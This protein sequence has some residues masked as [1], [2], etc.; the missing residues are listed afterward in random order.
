MRFAPVALA[1]AMVK[2]ALT[3][4]RESRYGCGGVT[5]GAVAGIVLPILLLMWTEEYELGSDDGR[6]GDAGVECGVVLRECG[7]GERRGAVV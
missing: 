4:D 7:D 1:Q 6:E 2:Y 3:A 5:G